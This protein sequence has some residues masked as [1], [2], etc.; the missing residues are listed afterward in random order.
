MTEA[1]RY[2]SA[3]TIMRCI[4]IRDNIIYRKREG[5][6]MVSYALMDFQEFLLKYEFSED[7][8]D[9][10]CEEIGR[11]DCIMNLSCNEERFGNELSRLFDMKLSHEII[12]E[13]FCSKFEEGDELC[14]LD[15]YVIDDFEELLCASNPYCFY[16]LFCLIDEDNTLG[17]VSTFTM[18]DEIDGYRVAYWGYEIET[19]FQDYIPPNLFDFCI[20][21]EI[22]VE[23]SLKY[24]SISVA[25]CRLLPIAFCNTIDRN[26]DYIMLMDE[27]RKLR[28][29]NSK[30]NIGAIKFLN[31]AEADRMRDL[32]WRPMIII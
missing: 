11:Y 15:Y 4:C 24:E 7:Q 13:I 1:F 32:K 22:P 14:L 9:R 23:V 17:R 21:Y 20:K 28:I 16:N 3:I 26:S 8:V 29:I 6:A 10:I 19:T 5:I 25:E 27:E 18:P 12:T 30:T 2:Y 31:Y